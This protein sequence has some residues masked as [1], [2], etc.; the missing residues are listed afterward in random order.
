MFLL[1]RL[2]WRNNPSMK[3]ILLLMVLLGSNPSFTQNFNWFI[4]PV[5]GDKPITE[6]TWFVSAQGDSI[7]LE[8]V[9][10][11]LSDIQWERAD[12]SII[13]DTVKARLVD[14]FDTS[15]L[16]IFFQIVDFKQIRTLRFNIG[17]DSATNV[18]GAMGGDLDPQKGMYWAWQ[19]GYI[20]LKIEGRSPQLT[21]R[22]N[23]FQ[24]HL[25]GYLQ[26]FYALRSVEL[27]VNAK[28]TAGGV[29]VVD[30]S[31]FFKNIHI[32]TQKSIMSP[33]KEAIPLA[34]FS[35]QMFSIE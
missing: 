10:F 12:K 27:P 29:L 26:P 7:L 23:Q 34:D 5:F 11:Y 16:Q 8:N 35:V 30:V 13:K 14:I 24:F 4:K 17:V 28:N 19:S 32:T 2:W 9:R 15:T 25:G 20:N 1:K 33:C 21:T 18:S 3:N 22:K 6:N 31:K